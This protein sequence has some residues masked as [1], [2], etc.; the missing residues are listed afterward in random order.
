M[1]R[2][3]SIYLLHLTVTTPPKPKYCLCV[4]AT[5]WLFLVNSKLRPFVADRPALSAQ[6]VR[7][8]VAGHQFLRYDSW[9]D[10][11]EPISIQAAEVARQCADDPS[12]EKGPASERVLEAVLRAVAVSTTLPERKKQAI[13]EALRPLIPRK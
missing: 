2:V 12:R 5:P 3:G 4:T 1:I 11:S 13:A 10:C 7:L 6:Q 8:P 9:I